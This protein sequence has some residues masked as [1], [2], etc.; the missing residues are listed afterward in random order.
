MNP[1]L[2]AGA[3]EVMGEGAVAARRGGGF[4]AVFQAESE[5]GQ[6]V[7]AVAFDAADQGVNREQVAGHPMGAVEKQADGRAAGAETGGDVGVNVHPVGQIGVVDALPRQGR[8]GFV[9]VIGAEISIAEEKKQVLKVR[10]A[11]LHQIGENGFHLRHGHGA[12]GDQILVPF[13]VTGAGD[14]GNAGAAAM[15]GQGVKGG[16]HRPFAAQKPQ[17]HRA[18]V[19]CQ[20][21]NFAA[22]T[23]GQRRRVD[24]DDR[25]RVAGQPRQGAFRRKDVGVGGGD[26]QYAFV[27]HN[28]NPG[29]ITFY[30]ATG[31]GRCGAM[32]VWG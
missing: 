22:V 5:H 24:R 13:L 28:P 21:H 10:N 9:A 2:A 20:R 6:D 17:R 16:G 4:G 30:I 27:S 3:G 23:G 31:L 32:P 12:G 25:R 14:E 26:Q 8:R 18:G 15:P 11:A 1:G 7:G 19:R 29:R